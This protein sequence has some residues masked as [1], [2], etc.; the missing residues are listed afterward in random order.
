MTSKKCTHKSSSS[1]CPMNDQVGHIPN[2]IC[3]QPKVEEHVEDVK[4][5]L[6]CIFRMQITIANSCESSD[7]PVNRC[8]ITDPQALFK[9][10]IH[11]GSNPCLLWVMITCGKKIIKACSTMNCK[12]GDL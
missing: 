9:E 1:T 8:H 11:G 6:P 3:C 7:R 4:D 12:N 10:V 2:Q 5:H